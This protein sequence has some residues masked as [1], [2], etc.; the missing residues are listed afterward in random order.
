[1]GLRI[2]I[3]LGLACG[4]A[5]AASDGRVPVIVELFTSE[6]C[7]SCPPADAVLAKL[8]HTQPV[9]G[10]RVIALSEHVDYWNTL[11]WVDPF[12][13]P[14]FRARQN[15]FAHAFGVESVYTP[16]MIV[17]GRAEFVGNDLKRASTEIE[18][19]ANQPLATV[20]L[21]TAGNQ[22]DPALIDLTVRVVDLPPIRVNAKKNGA[23]LQVV[24][25]ITE[26]NLSSDV[27][28]GE[29]SGRRLRHV[30]VVRSFGLI[31][32]LDPR[33]KP[34]MS[35]RTT[36]KFPPNWKRQDLHAVVFVQERASQ[37]ILGAESIDLPDSRTP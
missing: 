22:K 1:M 24:L 17:N 10:A 27:Q 14:Q 33:E 37:H 18:R 32:N 20:Q 6:G 30:A 4:A 15:D 35:V 21:E 12:S 16:Q 29:N 23:P 36:L 5:F 13:S 7:S 25:A 26:D 11:G 19:A 2:L 8:D 34:D 28:H 3:S 31:G 9:S